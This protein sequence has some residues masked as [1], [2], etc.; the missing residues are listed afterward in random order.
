MFE[1]T[2]KAWL[3]A[4]IMDSFKGQTSLSNEVGTPQGGVISPLLCNVALHGMEI[5]LLSHFGRYDVKIIRYA[6]DFVIMSKQL[7]KI[8]KAKLIVSDFLATVNLELSEEKTRIGHSLEA[9]NGDKPGLEFLGFY[10]RNQTTSIHR[11]VKNTRGKKQKFIQISGPSRG[12]MLN[13]KR[14]LKMILKKHKA[15]PLTAVLAKL[16]ARIRG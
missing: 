7:K 16:S 8:E 15:M 13:H 4:G 12:A 10:F 6:D 14:A 11:G 5:D 3:K 9:I 2:I 1:K